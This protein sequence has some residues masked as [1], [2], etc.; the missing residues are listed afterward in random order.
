MTKTYTA[1]EMR[2]VAD[3]LDSVYVA[4]E[5]EDKEEQYKFLSLACMM[6]RQA[7]DLMEREE[8]REKY[9]YGALWNGLAISN[10]TESIESA[11][12]AVEEINSQM[13]SPFAKLVRRPVGEWEEVRDGE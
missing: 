5:C 2:V 13:L 4:P 12:K 1:Q 10:R 3:N 9:E 7:A 11:R 6:L 8:K